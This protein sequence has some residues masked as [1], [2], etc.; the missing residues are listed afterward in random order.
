MD[1]WKKVA[2]GAAAVVVV[3]GGTRAAGLWGGSSSENS[4]NLSFQLPTPIQTLDISKNTDTYSGTIIGN[5]GANLM[6]V[7][8][9]GKAQL[10]LA[11]S[12]KVSDDGLKYTVVLKNGLKW[13]DGSKLTA[14]D[15][16][17]SWQRIVDPK[18]ASQYAYLA[19]GVK[20]ADKI[21][22]GKADVDTLGVTAKGNTITFDLERPLPQFE[23]LLTFSNFMPQKQNFVTKEGKK[24][25]TT[26]ATSLYSGPY[27]VEGWNG[28][29]NSFKLI[30]NDNYWD[31]KNIKTKQIDVQVVQK[32]ET[33]VQL[34]KQGKI[35]RV[36]ISN[37]PELYKANK[38]DKNVSKAPEAT[39]AYLQYNQTGKNKF[40]ANAKIREALN[41]ATNRKELT[42]QVTAGISTP[43]TGLAPEGLA[44]TDSGEDLAKFVAPGYK[45]DPKKAATLFQEGLKEVGESQATFTV[46][47]DADS[48]AAK[49]TLDYLQGSWEKAL[50]GLKINQ[51]FVPF[52]QRIKDSQTQNFD[53]VVS[54]WGGD[55]PEG[56]T[57]YDIF[58]TGASNN[59]GQFKNEV[60]DAAV[61]K[62]EST[63]AL[64]ASAR[65]NDYKMAEEALLKDSNFNPLYFRA[66][67]ALQNPKVT[68]IVLNST[69]LNQDWKLA[70]K[71]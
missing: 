11:K 2:I 17:Y 4:K 44:K 14:Q 71:K 12:V 1:T 57:Y 68:G 29:N 70:V 63:D 52:S 51:K 67:Y 46:T 61:N 37:T 31:A 66:G 13:S 33:A 41:L 69:G 58:K 38:N 27:K 30:K 3:G 42:D 23:Y 7:D 9:K 59:N 28:T 35:D 20:N 65:D 49:T 5:S 16:V 64:K 53:I 19:S 56:S 8:S 21:A 55:Y 62:A 25:A 18:T 43:A 54:L 6:R 10:E 26:A 39:T 50:P 36:L 32:P 34:Y 60:Y 40:L 47:S 48:P 15:F 22:A 24:Y 45:F